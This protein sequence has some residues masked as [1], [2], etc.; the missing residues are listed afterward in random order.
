MYK[1]KTPASDEDQLAKSS[2]CRK[3]K[4]KKRMSVWAFTAEEQSWVLS[5]TCTSY[6]IT[7]PFMR[8]FQNALLPNTFALGINLWILEKSHSNR[9][10][11]Q[12]HFCVSYAI[13]V[14]QSH[15]LLDKFSFKV[16]WPRH[17]FHV[18]NNY[19]IHIILLIKI[20]F[21]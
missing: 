11:M 18:S 12:K 5:S 6:S 19:L 8:I 10:T 3:W 1:N 4:G 20:P 15:F 14:V 16:K 17:M 2:Q 9:N 21:T 7:G 13:K